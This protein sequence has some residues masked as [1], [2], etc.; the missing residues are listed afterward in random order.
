MSGRFSHF[1][2]SLSFPS[3]QL[4]AHLLRQ[5]LLA[6]CCIAFLT[7]LATSSWKV[8][9]RVLF[10]NSGKRSASSLVQGHLWW[11]SYTIVPRHDMFRTIC[12]GKVWCFGALSLQWLTTTTFTTAYGTFPFGKRMES[13]IL[14]KQIKVPQIY[15]NRKTPTWLSFFG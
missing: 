8:T 10:S 5:A 14:P 11:G 15:Q 4:W 7:K 6:R 9:S 3:F 2:P 1:G 13:K 12:R